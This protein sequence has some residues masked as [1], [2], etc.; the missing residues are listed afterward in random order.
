ME[1]GNPMKN[2]TVSVDDAVYHRARVFAAKWDTSVSAVVAEIL[3]KM[4]MLKRMVDE[5]CA[6]DAARA[7]PPANASI[8]KSSS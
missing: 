5:A 2:I 6:A 3:E 8:K 4:P 7:N 1:T